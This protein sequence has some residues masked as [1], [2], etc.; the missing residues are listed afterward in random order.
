MMFVIYVFGVVCVVIDE[1]VF[2]LVYDFVVLC[3]ISGD[4]ILW[5]LVVE[6]EVVVCFGWVEVV[7][8]LCF[9]VDEIVVLCVDFN[10]KGVICVVFVGMG[11][12]FFVF[13]VIVQIV[14]VLLMI[15]D[16][17]VFGQVLVVFDEGFVDIVFVVLLKLGFIVEMDLQ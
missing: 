8:V 4:V 5:G 6:F 16:L 7:L 12:L 11:G 1:I 9:F 13:E 10:V 14:G 17:I 2:V 3:I 15:F